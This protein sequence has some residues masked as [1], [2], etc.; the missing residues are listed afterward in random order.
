M[1]TNIKIKN[2]KGYSSHGCNI[3]VQLKPNKLN[4]LLAPN[5]FGKTSLA[6]A[7]SSLKPRKLD[8]KDDDKFLK[9]TD[10]SSSLSITLDN[11]ELTA[12]N[13]HNDINKIIYPYVIKSKLVPGASS[14]TFGGHTSTKSFF[15]IEDIEVVDV[16]P[17]CSPKYKI[18]NVQ[19]H[20][21]KNGKIL[22]NLESQLS[23]LEFLQ[24]IINCFDCF[25]KFKAKIRTSLILE[26]VNKIN[27]LKGNANEIVQQCNTD[28]MLFADLESEPFYKK[29]ILEL[30]PESENSPIDNFLLFY[31]LLD[32]YKA[33]SR[34]IQ[35]NY[36]RLKYVAIKKNIEETLAS[37]NSTWKNTKVTETNKKL[38]VSYPHANEISNGQRDILT[39]V[40]QLI[41]FL[42][43]CPNNK[44]SLVIIDEVFDYLDDAN[45]IA[46]QYFLTKFL[47]NKKT[48]IYVVILT[49]LDPK[50]FRSYV[51]N[52]YLNI[53]TL[54][55]NQPVGSPQMKA[56]I[57]FRQNLNKEN[58]TT[59]I[60][61]HKLSHYF[62]H[63]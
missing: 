59:K 32:Y 36:N 26:V 4:I 29:A 23:N 22:S 14:K 56:F 49:H 37:L 53:N 25:E 54:V 52:K 38:L 45:M 13:S 10:L 39:F 50:Y 7:F 48:D 8:V 21:G 47:K 43:I 30:D 20:F 19:K 9:N 24:M 41:S 63:T 15:N 6:T 5:G 42:A 51:F 33:D 11:K 17:S 61:Y 18:R 55:N 44:K 31:Q 12:D 35:D 1:I 27:V 46:A 40:V 2:I 34:N 3:D 28:T 60:L 16:S 62:F 57:S 58:E